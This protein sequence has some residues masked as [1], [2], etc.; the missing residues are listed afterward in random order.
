MKYLILITCLSLGVIIF[1]WLRNN[2]KDHF[3]I[4]L[5]AWLSG[6]SWNYP[7]ALIEWPSD[8]ELIRRS[9]IRR[10]RKGNVIPFPTKNKNEERLISNIKRMA[11]ERETLPEEERKK[12]NIDIQRCTRIPLMIQRF[13]PYD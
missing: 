9:R 3:L 12:S 11:K 2:K 6:D 7:N 5:K 4:R 8:F 1:S 10:S 13:P